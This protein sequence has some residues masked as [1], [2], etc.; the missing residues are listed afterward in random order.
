M[1]AVKKLNIYLAADEYNSRS[2][3]TKKWLWAL[4]ILVIIIVALGVGL[5]IGLKGDPPPPEYVVR[6]SGSVVSNGGECA[7]IG[8]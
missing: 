4:L 7:A 3:V 2:S 5:G 1:L 6:H 8:G